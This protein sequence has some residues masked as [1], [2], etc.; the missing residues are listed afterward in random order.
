MHHPS[1]FLCAELPLSMPN[2]SLY[3]FVLARCSPSRVSIFSFTHVSHVFTS[4]ESLLACLH[5]ICVCHTC[6]F[7]FSCSLTS[8]HRRSA[9]LSRLA[10]LSFKPQEFARVCHPKFLI[11]ISKQ[12]YTV[13]S[14]ASWKSDIDMPL[15]CH[16]HAT[17]LPCVFVSHRSFSPFSFSPSS[18]CTIILSYRRLVLYFTKIKY[19]YRVSS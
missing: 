15:T 3:T 4:L 8:S 2:V 10:N 11:E 5:T 16:V 6:R 18:F 19:V 17:P 14:S 13:P 9:C 12:T 7:P 1:I